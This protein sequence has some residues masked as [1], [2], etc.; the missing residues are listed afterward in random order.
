MTT[1]LDPAG[2]TTMPRSTHCMCPHYLRPAP[3]WVSL[4]QLPAPSVPSHDLCM[5]FPFPTPQCA[6]PTWTPSPHDCP[7][8]IIQFS[9]CYTCYPTHCPLGHG[10]TFLLQG[11]LTGW[12]LPVVPSHTALVPVAFYITFT[13][14]VPSHLRLWFLPFCP[15]WVYTCMP[16]SWFC[17][18][19]L[20]LRLTLPLLLLPSHTHYTTSLPLYHPFTPHT[21]TPA[22]THATPHTPPAPAHPTRL[23]TAPLPLPLQCLA[24]TACHMPLRS[25]LDSLG[26]VLG[27]RAVAHA[28]VRQQLATTPF[29]IIWTMDLPA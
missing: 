12:L 26:L 18:S 10:C 14:Y 21:H 8:D 13:L 22:P 1:H 9:G 11:G 3:L 23:P 20:W 4:P 16:S 28:P 2:I 29:W 17:I 5:Q 19:C 25:V 24:A 7:W 6:F 27:K 15:F